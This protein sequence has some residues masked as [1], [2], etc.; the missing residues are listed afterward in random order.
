VKAGVVPVELHRRTGG[1]DAHAGENRPVVEGSSEDEVL[2][3]RK[4]I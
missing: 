1:N 4:R 3:E 2:V